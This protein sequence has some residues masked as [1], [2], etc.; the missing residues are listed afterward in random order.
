MAGFFGIG[1]SILGAGSVGAG[2]AV[3]A[4]SSSNIDPYAFNGNFNYRG[5]TI[6]FLYTYAKVT[7]GQKEIYLVGGIT[8]DLFMLEDLYGT[9]SVENARK[10]TFCD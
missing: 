3:F 9:T 5:G 1:A 2:T 6:G 4:D 10:E 8:S 7:M